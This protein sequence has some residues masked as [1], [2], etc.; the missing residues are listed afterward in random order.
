[1]ASHRPGTIIRIHSEDL[2]GTNPTTF[3]EYFQEA[4][5]GTH[6]APIYQCSVPDSLGNLPIIDGDNATSNVNTSSSGAAGE[7]GVT[8]FGSLHGG[9]TPNGPFQGG[10]YGPRD[11]YFTGLHIRNFIGGHNFLWPGSPSIVSM[12]RGAPY[13]AGGGIHV[14][15]P[16]SGQTDGTYYGR[17]GTGPCT[18][19][20]AYVTVSGGQVVSGD[21][22]SGGNCPST[23]STLPTFTPSAGGTPGTMT[24]NTIFSTVT[25]TLSLSDRLPGFAC[26]GPVLLSP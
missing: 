18:G 1:M 14:T 7:G 21:I 11:I 25:M 19:A 12:S 10:P 15:T 20:T 8:T 22:Q 4:G 3:H 5:S 9:S 2:T 13:A 23:S 26:D 6:T 24:A 17:P 16:G